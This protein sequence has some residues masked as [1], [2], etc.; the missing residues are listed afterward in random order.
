MII[1]FNPK[2]K[3]DISELNK[4]IEK[5][6][7]IER[8]EQQYTKRV[9]NVCDNI[10]K[11]DAPIV[12][13]TG[14]S[15]S[16]KT[17]SCKRIVAELEKRGRKAVV[18]SLDNF[19]KNLEDYPRDE[20]GEI[21]LDSVYAVDI[22]LVNLFIKE[23]IEHGKALMPEFD[24]MKQGRKEQKVEIDIGKDGIAILEGIHALNPL[25]YEN[26]APIDKIFKIYIGL[27]EEYYIDGERVFPT[28]DIRITRRFVRDRQFRGYPV[29]ATFKN[30][31]N[32][33]RGE[34]L[35]IRPFKDHASIIL[36][37]SFEYEPAVFLP[38]VQEIVDDPNEGGIYREQ[39]E[40]I[41]NTLKKFVAITPESVPQNSVLREFIGGLDIK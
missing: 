12:L 35:Y 7:F 28:R 26:S 36:D 20:N 1:N 10:E 9:E 33:M 21:D 29:E 31:K 39:L 16:G 38:L 6:D 19:F 23:I 13:A 4:E 11:S 24:F 18:V 5:K 30:W 27:R 3:I 15:A 2:R 40:R 32:I 8:C 22:E 37:T 14:P 41:Y 17:T 34:D 25:L